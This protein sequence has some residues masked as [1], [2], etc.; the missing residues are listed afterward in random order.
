MP[1]VYA[2]A[3]G[4]VERDTWEERLLT[5]A[6]APARPPRARLSPLVGQHAG[7]GA[8]AVAA[9]AWTARSGRM[10]G[11]VAIAEAGP[12]LVH[13]IARG[14]SHIALVVGPADA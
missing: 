4:D 3:S 2:S 10:P 7:A 6:L 13:G 5:R 11:G 9:A 14:G 1:W 12:G 8:L